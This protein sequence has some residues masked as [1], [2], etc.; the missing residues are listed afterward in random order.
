LGLEPLCAGVHRFDKCGWLL[1]GGNVVLPV[2][3]VVPVT[4]STATA[5]YRSVLDSWRVSGNSPKKLGIKINLCDYRMPESGATTDPVMLGALIDAIREKFTGVEII[6][7]ENDATSVEAHSLVAC[8][9]F[10]PLFKKYGVSFRSLSE[11]GWVS[12]QVPGG[13][14]F[15][16]LEIPGDLERVDAWI[17]FTKLKTNGITKTTGCLKNNF[18]FLRTKK[19]SVF[20]GDMGRVLV[21]INKVIRAD[22]NIVDGYIGMEG[23]GPAFGIPKKCELLVGGDDPVAVDACCARIMGFSPNSVGHIREAARAGIGS[24]SYRLETEVPGFRYKNYRFR[25]SRTEYVLKRVL[26]KLTHL[27]AAG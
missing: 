19:K 2:V 20:H 8:L 25:F 9:G 18:A 24:I 12:R 23:D 16:D 5:A 26:R 14:V 21:D 7:W 27:G 3:K 1:I 6:I 15:H 22:F 17:N 11:T 4:P 10:L 13:K